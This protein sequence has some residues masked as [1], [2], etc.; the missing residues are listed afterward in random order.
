MKFTNSRVYNNGY[1]YEKSLL[2][3]F[4]QQGYDKLSLKGLVNP[5]DLFKEVM[6]LSKG[7]FCPS[8]VVQAINKG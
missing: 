2:Y 4:L 5:N 8:E 7:R 6:K 1:F 3:K